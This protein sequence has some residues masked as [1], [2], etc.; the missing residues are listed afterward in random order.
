MTGETTRGRGPLEGT[1]CP[2]ESDQRPP[3]IA[4]PARAARHPAVVT[5]MASLEASEASRSAAVS[6]GE[7]LLSSRTS[8]LCRFHRAKGLLCAARTLGSCLHTFLQRAAAAPPPTRNTNRVFIRAFLL[9]VLSVLLLSGGDVSQSAH[10]LA[11]SKR[12]SEQP[13]QRFRGIL[14]PQGKRISLAALSAKASAA[15]GGEA[16]AAFAESRQAALADREVFRHSWDEPT[17]VL[18]ADVD[19]AQEE[20]PPRQ[21]EEANDDAKESVTA[22]FTTSPL[23]SGSAELWNATPAASALELSLEVSS[24]ALFSGQAGA[25]SVDMMPD[26]EEQIAMLPNCLF[27]VSYPGTCIPE[28]AHSPCR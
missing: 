12:H 19:S 13:R 17:N 14:Q 25:A 1:L 9:A 10:A 15:K 8:S 20:Q 23:H 4:F 7:A 11:P 27:Y 16:A 5:H 26:T 22:Y 3:H 24:P 21:H 28:T 6:G 2:T 18:H